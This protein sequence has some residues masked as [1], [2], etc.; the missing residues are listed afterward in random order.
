MAGRTLA[1]THAFCKLSVVRI[2]FVTIGAL[3]K[4]QRLFEI[5]TRM[6]L[7][8]GYTGVLAFK[9][10][11]RFGVI[12]FL[13]DRLQ[14]DFLPACGAVTG[15]AALR[16]TAAMRI[17]VAIRALGKRNANVLWLSVGSVCVAL[18][19]LHLLVKAAQRI[20]G[21]RVIELPNFDR[22]PVLVIVALQTVLAKA[23]FVLIL[24]AGHACRRNSKK[25][26]VQVLIF[27]GC[28]FW[29]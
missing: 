13:V 28:T 24:V 8:A 1:P 4:H 6:A 10:V 14:R 5:A 19:A 22:L 2:W 18:G 27:D 17:L 12:K 7:L 21:F 20:A 3:A 26:A 15:R 25:T 9:R 23:P 29:W 11:L 16:E